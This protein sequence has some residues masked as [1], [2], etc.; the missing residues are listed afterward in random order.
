M[1]HADPRCTC[2]RSACHRPCTTTSTHSARQPPLSAVHKDPHKS[3]LSR[4][5]Y[6]TSDLLC[7]RHCPALCSI[8]HGIVTRSARHPLCTKIRSHSTRGAHDLLCTTTGSACRPPT[9]LLGVLALP[10]AHSSPLRLLRSPPRRLASCS[11]FAARRFACG[12]PTTSARWRRRSLWP[13][14]STPRLGSIATRQA[15][16]GHRA[17]FWRLKGLV[18]TSFVVF[19]FEKRNAHFKVFL[20]SSEFNR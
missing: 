7:T 4:T 2:N 16:D 8:L 9:R 3:P 18:R 14:T 19:A 12:C 10:A 13:E 1:N 6:P 17:G 15:H 5:I 20:N 11:R